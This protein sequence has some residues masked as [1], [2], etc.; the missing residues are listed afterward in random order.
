MADGEVFPAKNE[1]RPDNALQE[2]VTTY[3]THRD[4]VSRA[5]PAADSRL[6][7]IREQALEAFKNHLTEERCLVIHFRDMNATQLGRILA[8]HP[9]LA[10]PLMI[11]CNVAERAIERDLGLKGLN[12]Y[13]PRFQRDAAKAVAGYL[14]PFLP[15]RI[16]LE[17]FCAI[18]RLMF[19]DK[20]IRKGKG[21]WELMVRSALNEAAEREGFS[22]NFKKRTFKSA[23]EAFEIDAAHPP[24]GPISV[25]VDVKRIEARRDIHKRCD[26]IVNKASKFK[27]EF[28]SGKFIAFIYYPFTEEH[29]NVANRL[30]SEEIDVVV[31]ASEHPES[32]RNA[33]L[34]A[35]KTKKSKG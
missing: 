15:D 31:F 25:A 20:E 16:E 13:K 14:K 27:R 23:G 32:V 11:L 7:I 33:A 26:E 24:S 6:D 29:T 22:E 17:S 30:Q 21:R 9:V 5:R 10:K 2:P 3:A 12:S 4:Y 19:L 1:D 8:A 34:T 35:L 18:D 28:R